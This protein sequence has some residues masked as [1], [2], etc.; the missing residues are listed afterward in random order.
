MKVGL[1][2]LSTIGFILTAFVL[3]AE[4]PGTYTNEHIIYLLDRKSVV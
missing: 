3:A 4:L 2:I 1:F